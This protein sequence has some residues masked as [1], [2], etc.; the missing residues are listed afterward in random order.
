M[1]QVEIAGAIL[2]PALLQCHSGPYA[3]PE[4]V[5]QFRFF[6][7]LLTNDDGRRWC[8]WDGSSYD[9]AIAISEKVR[10]HFGVDT[11]TVDL[12]AGGAS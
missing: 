8:L 12:V 7:T 11:P 5:G 2:T 10:T 1:T 3:T 4:N 9:E 6:V